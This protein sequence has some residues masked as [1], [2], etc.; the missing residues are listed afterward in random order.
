MLWS[1]RASLLTRRKGRFL[2]WL[3]LFPL[4]SAFL[5]VCLLPAYLFWVLFCHSLF[6]CPPPLLCS[7]S[8]G[9][10]FLSC[11]VFWHLSFCF[12]LWFICVSTSVYP[13]LLSFLF[14]LSSSPLS[15]LLQ[16]HTHTHL[17]KQTQRYF[18]FYQNGSEI[19]F[20]C[21]L[22]KIKWGEESP[23]LPS[24]VLGEALWGPGDLWSGLVW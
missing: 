8:S 23:L 4:V 10:V 1:T 2:L 16:T 7:S 24:V 5:P 22:L 9:I 14:L 18:K 11:H 21:P 13:A 6:I 12:F 17:L 20:I 15:S 3:A 19:P